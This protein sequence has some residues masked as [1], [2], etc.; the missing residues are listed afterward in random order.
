MAVSA[1]DVKKLREETDAPMMECKAAL[2]EAGGDFEK[3][4]QILREK[5]QAAATKRAGRSTSEGLAFATAS[6]PKVAA[7]VVECET[8]FVAKNADFVAMVHKLANGLLSAA[9]PAAGEVVELGNDAVVEGKTIATWMEEAV[10]VI[11]ENI[12]C[13]TAVVAAAPAGGTVGTYNHHTGKQAAFVI[14]SGDASNLADIGSKIAIQVVAF[15]PSFLKREDV[16]QDVIEKEISTEVARAVN[17]GKPADVAEK[18][19]RGRVQ[20]EYYQTMVLLEQPFYADAKQ[21]TGEFAASQAK[22]VGGTAEATAYRLLA[23]GANSGE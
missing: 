5:G 11:R 23:V 15:P 22:G 2:D 8:D 21:K 10:A 9:D 4:R 1:A 19:A 20:K 6:G 12:V 17:E 18:I 3:A 13:K 7:V 16:P 14:M